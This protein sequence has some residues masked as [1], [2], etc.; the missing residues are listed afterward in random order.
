MSSARSAS[1]ISPI[2]ASSLL[3]S[4]RRRPVGSGQLKCPVDGCNKSFLYPTSLYRHKRNTHGIGRKLGQLK[5]CGLV[6]ETAPLWQ[7][8]RANSHPELGDNPISIVDIGEQSAYEEEH[9]TDYD[10]S[11]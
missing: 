10:H 11:L 2:A 5:C 8:H 3:C 4:P 6:F 1:A 9:C 7:V